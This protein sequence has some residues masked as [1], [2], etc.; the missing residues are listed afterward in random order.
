MFQEA[1]D[2]VLERGRAGRA[3]GARTLQCQIHNPVL[4]TAIGNIAA[5]ASYSRTH[6]RFEQFV[7]LCHDLLIGG[8][9]INQQCFTVVR[10]N[11][12]PRRVTASK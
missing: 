5:I 6:P 10:R 4:E 2:A 9:F 12:E 8:I 1:F 7:D 3:A 11:G